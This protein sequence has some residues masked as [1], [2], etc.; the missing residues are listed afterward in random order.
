MTICHYGLDDI[1]FYEKKNLK[2]ERKKKDKIYIGTNWHSKNRQKETKG[3][4]KK[5]KKRKKIRHQSR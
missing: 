2:K 3:E 4:S 1:S 5:E